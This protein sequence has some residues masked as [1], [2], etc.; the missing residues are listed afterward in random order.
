M[1][2]LP[3]VHERLPKANIYA[4]WRICT[5]SR[6]SLNSNNCNLFKMN[7]KIVSRYWIGKNKLRMIG[8]ITHIHWLKDIRRKM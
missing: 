2:V 1:M 7:F 8:V 5:I 4:I 6:S 3:Y